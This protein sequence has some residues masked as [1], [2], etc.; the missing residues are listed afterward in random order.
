MHQIT[1][2]ICIVS[3][4]LLWPSPSVELR[5]R[6]AWWLSISFFK[7][8]PYP[9]SPWTI[10]LDLYV[11]C[12][13]ADL[14]LKAARGQTAMTFALT[15]GCN[16]IVDILDKHQAILDAEEAEGKSLEETGF[17]L[18]FR[19]LPEEHLA[20]ICSLRLRLRVFFPQHRRNVWMFR[21]HLEVL[22]STV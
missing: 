10:P 8:I 16:A 7:E 17:A 18:H 20:I 15:N 11:L 2:I 13:Q 4:H 22:A 14:S 5:L 6:I 3:I 1:G 9:W 21:S 19:Y 12:S